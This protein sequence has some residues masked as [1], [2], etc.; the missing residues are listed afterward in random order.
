MEWNI[1]QEKNRIKREKN[2]QERKKEGQLDILR[3]F[4]LPSRTK[5][6]N[7]FF[8]FKDEN[9]NPENLTLKNTNPNIHTT[10]RPKLKNVKVKYIRAVKIS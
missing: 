1:K 6:F 10:G 4:Y 5:E 2:I 8:A 3:S 9:G 7:R